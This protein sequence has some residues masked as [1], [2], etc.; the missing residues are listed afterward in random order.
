MAAFTT[1][2]RDSKKMHTTEAKE[3][4]KKLGQRI[5]ELRMQKGWSQEQLAHESGLGRASMGAIERGE[6]SIRLSS[7]L[8]LS[9][10]LGITGSELLKGT[11]GPPKAVKGSS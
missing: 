6:V 1:K 4:H 11:E 3:V 5:R 8:K 9:N 7:L 2:I 10:A